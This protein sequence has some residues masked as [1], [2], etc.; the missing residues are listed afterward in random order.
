MNI[1][2]LQ[3]ND[4]VALI[5]P[6]GCIEDDKPVLAAEQWLTSVGLKSMRG[7]FVLGK[8]GVFSGTDKER[9]TDFQKALDNPDIKAVWAV[10]GGYGAMRIMAHL[11]FTIFK[12]HPKWLIGFSDITAFHNQWHLMNLPSVHGIMP[13]QIAKNRTETTDALVSLR[14][15]LFG[16]RLTYSIPF[17][18]N[19]KTGVAEGVLVGGNL[20]LLQS[21]TGTPYE[22]ETKGKI[23]FI[24]DVGEYA[25]RVDR[26]LQS[27]KLAG[28]FNQLAGLVVGGFTDIKE[29][30][31]PFGKNYRRMILDV[32]RGKKYPVLFD[33]PA[34]H[35]PD[36]RTLIFGK[37]IRLDVTKIHSRLEYL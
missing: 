14:K 25:Y 27:L 8:K 32:T 37:K 11:D 31:T 29:G 26:T 3:K 30:G 5:A 7:S 1:P 23:L 15:A 24:E 34:G 6:A 33:F 10:R 16:E 2:F 4:L 35:F 21:L 13:V 28:V 18:K 17:S 9:L 20:T 12:K 19:N 22:I 36:N